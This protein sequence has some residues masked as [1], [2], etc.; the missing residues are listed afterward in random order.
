MQGIQDINKFNDMAQNNNEIDLLNN[1][2][3]NKN[4]WKDLGY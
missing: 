1:L 2:D 3:Y 4:L